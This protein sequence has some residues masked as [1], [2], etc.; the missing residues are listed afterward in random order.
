[1]NKFDKRIASLPP[2]LYLTVAQIDELSGQWKGGLNLSP[3]TLGRLKR[4]ALATSTGSSTRIEGAV[5]SDEEVEDLMRGLSTQ[6]MTDRDVQEVRGYYELLQEVFDN[7][8]NMSFTENAIL[9]L[10]NRL[11]A[12]SY[13]DERHKGGYKHIENHVEAKDPEG[14]TVG[15]IF[16]TTPAYLTPKVMGELVSWTHD[17]FPS[18]QSHPLIVIGS[19]IVEFLKIHPFVYGNGRLSRIL[20]NLLLLRSGYGYVPYVSHERIIENSKS[21]YYISLRRSQTT[22]GTDN[23]S[24][25]A[26]LEFFFGVLLEQAKQAVA[27]LDKEDIE[28]LLSPQ[29]LKVWMYLGGA[30]EAT[31]GTIADA[32]G[33][34]R[35]TVSQALSRL[36]EMKKVERI[37]KGS[38]TRYRRLE[39]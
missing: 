14:Q 30:S 26:W 29:Q 7:Y 20:T 10:H 34:A 16:E 23:E 6:K 25:I 31:P 3:Q 32:T 15:V 2:S 9:H 17:A 37:G 39:T 18:A 8:Q 11:L 27:L 38:T 36:L 13:K 12:Y 28:K 21:E 24:V 19:F 35:A 1:M 4:S 5:L 22:F 33:V